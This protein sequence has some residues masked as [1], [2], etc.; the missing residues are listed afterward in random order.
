MADRKFIRLADY[1][2]VHWET[3]EANR[4]WQ[5][6]PTGDYGIFVWGRCMDCNYDWLHS[7]RMKTVFM[8]ICIIA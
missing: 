3:G 2:Q 4:C 1:V 5:H 6:D 7:S 8:R